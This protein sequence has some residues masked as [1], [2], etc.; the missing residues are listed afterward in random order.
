MKPI[1]LSGP[2]LS[3]E[4]VF[5][6]KGYKKFHDSSLEKMKY[7]GLFLLFCLNRFESTVI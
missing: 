4:K 6:I 2:Y 1:F 3:I 5:R 7:L